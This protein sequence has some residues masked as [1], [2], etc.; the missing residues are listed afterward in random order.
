MS[1]RAGAAAHLDPAYVGILHVCVANQCRSPMAE[2]FGR[3]QVAVHPAARHLRITSAG[4]RAVDGHPMHPYAVAA[5]DRL[6]VDHRE[7]ASR[8]ATAEVLTA[9]D[10]ILT[11]TA[12]E[13]DTVVSLLPAALRTTFTLLEFARLAPAV[14]APDP[15]GDPAERARAVVAAAL[16][17]RG[18]LPYAGPDADDIPDPPRTPV[19]FERCAATIADAS[20]AVVAALCGPPA[21]RVLSPTA[22]RLLR[23]RTS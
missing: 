20:A 7:F 11:A 6:G 19:A 5:L 10:L 16:R 18:R 2:R 3:H 17:L 14:P 23:T 21:E 8:R 22:D 13:R 15:G 1:E 9:A 4:V 12:A